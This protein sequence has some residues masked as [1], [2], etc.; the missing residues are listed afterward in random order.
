MHNSVS[1]YVCQ[2]M[3]EVGRRDAHLSHGA[4]G[5]EAVDEQKNAVQIH[6]ARLA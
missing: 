4:E 1:K 3:N 2:Y 6:A 5:Y